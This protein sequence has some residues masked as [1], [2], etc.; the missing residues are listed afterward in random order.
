M[1][2]SVELFWDSISSPDVILKFLVALLPTS[3]SVYFAGKCVSL[4]NLLYHVCE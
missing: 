4:S 1:T 3:E 2:D